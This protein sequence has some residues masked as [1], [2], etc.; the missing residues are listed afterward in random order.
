MSLSRSTA[1]HLPLNRQEAIWKRFEIDLP[2]SSLCGWVMKTAEL[3][4]PLINELRQ[5][6]IAYDLCA[7]R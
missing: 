1:D 2:R 5:R 4:E 6:I 3:C 7:G